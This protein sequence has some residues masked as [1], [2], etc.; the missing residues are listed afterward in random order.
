MSKGPTAKREPS[1]EGLGLNPDDD[2]SAVGAALNPAPLAR[3]LLGGAK[4]R[5]LQFFLPLGNALFAR[6]EWGDLRFLYRNGRSYCGELLTGAVGLTGLVGDPPKPEPLFEP[7]PEP[8]LEPNPELD[9]NPEPLL[10]PNP[11]PLLDPKPDPLL[12]PNPEPLPDPKPVPLLDPKPVPVV[13]VALVP[14]MLPLMLV[15]APAVASRALWV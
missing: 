5:D 12:D 4:P 3:V 10:D 6:A 13:P 1:P 8:L 2:L 9:P 14:V 15:G 11:D 7:D